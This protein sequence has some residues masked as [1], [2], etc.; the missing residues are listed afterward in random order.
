VASKLNRREALKVGATLLAG[1]VV[2]RSDAATSRAK[3]VIVAG[4]GVAG[5]SCAYELMEMG[6]E[7]TLLEASRR[8]GG[9]VKTIREPLPAGLYADVGAENFPRPGYD[10]FWRYVEKFGLTA[11]PWPRRQNQQRRIN[12]RWYSYAEMNDPAILKGLGF[13]AAEVEFVVKHGLSELATLYLEPYFAKFK[14][15]Y[16]PFGVGL[17]HLDTML[18]GDLLAQAGASDAA[19][20]FSGFGRRATAAN[21]PREN[22]ASALY[23]LW[24]AAILKQRGLPLQPKEIFRLKGGNQ[25]LTDAFTAR[26]GDRVR[27]N[28]PVT[29]IEQ[30]DTAVTVHFEG[31]GSKQTMAADYLVVCM[32]PLSLSVVD[33]TP[34]WSPVKAYALRHTYLGMHSRVLLQTKTPF[35][36]G[37]IPS[38]NLL[39]GDPRMGSVCETAEE[40]PGECRLLFGTG[41]PVQTAEETLAAFRS[42]YP[43]KA[44]DTIEQVIVHQ[45]WKE[46][47]TCVGCEREPFPFGQMTRIWPFL[48]EPVGR[49]HFAGAAY[50][51]HWRGV[52]AATRSA[53]RAARQIDAA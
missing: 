17:D 10:D 22:D 29:R 5:L 47:P 27:R 51:N 15:E 53:N 31:G 38:I 46:E 4:G 16:Q 52:E 32:S 6:H 41:R 26:L 9:H 44:K 1:L 7:V 19:V 30:S 34:A 8:T 48:I 14:D 28:A 23:R 43:G 18:P 20:R 21:P 24:I 33:V 49:I 36:K 35:W 11:L 3:K 25:V 37:D 50:D 12:G 2:S 42:F 39:T 40:V 45:W 13:L